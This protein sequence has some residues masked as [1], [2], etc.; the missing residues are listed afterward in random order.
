MYGMSGSEVVEL[1]FCPTEMV[2]ISET[3]ASLR[4]AWMWS[5]V[6]ARKLWVKVQAEKDEIYMKPAPP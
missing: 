2:V 1:K 3:R 4:G 5:T 6:K